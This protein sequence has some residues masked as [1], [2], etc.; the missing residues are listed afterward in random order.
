MQDSLTANLFRLIRHMRSQSQK[1][2]DDDKSAAGSSS[3][4][5]SDIKK[6]QMSEK[7]PFLALP[8]EPTPVQL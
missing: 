8:D 7:F 3:T 5:A 1:K 6:K 4:F 2:T